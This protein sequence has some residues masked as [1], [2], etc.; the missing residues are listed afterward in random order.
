MNLKF[1][2]KFI[3]LI[4]LNNLI[5]MVLL[6]SLDI[7]ILK[8][9]Y[10]KGVTTT[11]DIANSYSWEDKPKELSKIQR[12]NFF[13]AKTNLIEYRIKRLAKDGL[14]HIERNSEKIFVLDT[15]RVIIKK[16]K[17]PSGYKNA[18]LIKDLNNSWIIFQIN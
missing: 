6:D 11:W 9:I 15:K 4:N 17:F 13:S 12:N 8:K 3:K 5:K 10:L 16:H 7:V 18:L 14:I 1:I 2:V